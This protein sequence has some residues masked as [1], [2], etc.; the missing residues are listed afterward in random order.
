V[1]VS[2]PL[3]ALDDAVAAEL[4]RPSEFPEGSAAERRGLRMMI[5][6]T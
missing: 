2:G 5:F 4:E 6:N 1:S 3:E